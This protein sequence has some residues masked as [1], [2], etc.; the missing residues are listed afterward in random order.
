MTGSKQARQ[1]VGIISARGGSKG[2]PRKNLRPLAGKPLI[3]YAIE[4]ALQCSSLNRVIV[5][6]KDEEIA[7]V[8]REYGA[9]VPF[10]RPAELA[11]DTAGHWLVWQHAITAM[12]AESGQKIAVL[13]ELQPTS[14]LRE[15]EDIEGCV[16]QLL[17]SEADAVVTVIEARKHP[18]FSMVRLEAGTLSLLMPLPQPIQYRQEAP[19]V[20]EL[21]GAVY[22]LRRDFLLK[23][24]HLFDGHIEGYVTP[25]ERSLDID[26]ELDFAIAEFVFERRLAKELAHEASQGEQA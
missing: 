25:A 14:P 9:E 22:A 1:T 5:S 23:R 16:Q 8:A 3:A 4:A 12:E 24:E 17:K 6:T 11:T 2:V 20:Y 18:S 15:A 10:L 19:E 26:T 21:T 7:D 13:V